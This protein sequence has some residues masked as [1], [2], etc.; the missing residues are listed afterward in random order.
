[1]QQAFPFFK[2]FLPN[3]FKAIT[4]L[5]FTNSL[6]KTGGFPVQIKANFLW[7]RLQNFRARSAGAMSILWP[8]KNA[9]L[10]SNGAFFIGVSASLLNYHFPAGGEIISR[11]GVGNY[12]CCAKR[13]A[14]Q[15]NL[16]SSSYTRDFT[17][18]NLL[19]S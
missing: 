7:R 8:I 1:M 3:Y 9:P 10:R 15:N 11:Q 12:A 17:V 2:S 18:Q 16:I 5:F 6:L 19:T 4:P 14:V 13:S